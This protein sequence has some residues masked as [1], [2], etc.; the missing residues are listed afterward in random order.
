M[1]P[2]IPEAKLPKYIISWS[3]PLVALRGAPM[4]KSLVPPLGYEWS[5]ASAMSRNLQSKFYFGKTQSLK[6]EL[7][8]ML[9]IPGSGA[10]GRTR[11]DRKRVSYSSRCGGHYKYTICLDRI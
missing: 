10:F 8:G 5:T 1:E 11:F 7:F 3:A 4:E 2:L 6:P 9:R